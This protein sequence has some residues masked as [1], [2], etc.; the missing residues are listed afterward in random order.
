MHL[1]CQKGGKDLALDP[2]TPWHAGTTSSGPLRGD[3][4]SSRDPDQLSWRWLVAFAQAGRRP[5]FLGGVLCRPGQR[6]DP[7]S[8][9][10]RK[11][12]GLQLKPIMHAGV[13]SFHGEGI[14]NLGTRT[15]GSKE[16]NYRSP[17]EG[18]EDTNLEPAGR[19]REPPETATSA[20]T[21]NGC[22]SGDSFGMRAVCPQR[23]TLRANSGTRGGK[24]LPDCLD[25]ETWAAL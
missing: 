21:V 23:L 4:L 6:I 1:S 3:E 19:R 15:I 18:R 9:G 20:G 16:G 17:V 25:K 12:V 13:V 7:E 8:R 5:K 10:S 22:F 11:Y 14:G 24:R 2:S